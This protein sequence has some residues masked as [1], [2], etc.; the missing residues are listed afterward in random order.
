MAEC[1][2]YTG[3]D[4]K[5]QVTITA[6]GFSQDCDNYDIDFYCGDQH[7][8]FNQDD[9]ISNGGK[10]YLAIPTSS[11]SPGM[12]RMVITAYVPDTDFPGNIRK[13]IAVQNL[14]FL[15]SIM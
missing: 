13:E 2:Y 15:K 12:L 4:L 7:L 6:P 14:G 11:M 5:F 3:S 10:F 8:A 9:V 1:R